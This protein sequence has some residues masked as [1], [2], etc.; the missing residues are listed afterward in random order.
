M[1]AHNVSAAIDKLL[2]IVF[3]K[4][5]LLI[6]RGLFDSL[7]GLIWMIIEPILLSRE[8]DIDRLYARYKQKMENA[9]LRRK[10]RF[11]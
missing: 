8:E 9:R 6:L 10:Y 7:K 4:V 11:R 1:A 2:S 5:P 3:I